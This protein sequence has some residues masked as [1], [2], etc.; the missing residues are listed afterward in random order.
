MPAMIKV[1][2]VREGY[3]VFMS[4]INKHPEEESNQGKYENSKRMEFSIF[5]SK[6]NKFKQHMLY[7]CIES[8]NLTQ[9]RI[10][11]TFGADSN[12]KEE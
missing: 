8:V 11:V 6:S 1:G 2:G 9:M 5:N 4:T 7:I 10:N 12:R 3:K